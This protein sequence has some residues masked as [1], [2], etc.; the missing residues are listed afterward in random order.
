MMCG[1]DYFQDF[2]KRFF[3][4]KRFNSF[5]PILFSTELAF[6]LLGLGP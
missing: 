1:N 3:L 5:V 4:I 6:K 2:V